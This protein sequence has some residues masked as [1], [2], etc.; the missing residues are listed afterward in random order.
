MAEVGLAA[1][2]V[3]E[4]RVI[5]H[6][7]QHVHDVGVRLLDFVEQHD[8]VG[9]LAHGVH[10]QAALLEADV[11]RR[12]PDEP[13]HRVLLHVLAHVEAGELVAE[14]NRQLL[15]ELRLAHTGRAGEQEAAGRPIGH[16]EPRP[17]ALDRARYQR[18]RLLLS[19]D[20]APERLFERPEPLLV[21]G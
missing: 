8:V 11:S 2:V 3:R 15:C 14:M 12:R 16:A 18:H 4:R 17:R 5:H 7:Q 1:G 19:E 21:R 6:L 10:E 20:D 13:R 9:M